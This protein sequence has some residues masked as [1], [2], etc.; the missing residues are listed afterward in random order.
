[1]QL[2]FIPAQE[3]FKVCVTVRKRL[4]VKFYWLVVQVNSNEICNAKGYCFFFSCENFFT[5]SVFCVFCDATFTFLL[6]NNEC[7]FF[8]LFYKPVLLGV[9]ASYEEPFL[10]ENLRTVTVCNNE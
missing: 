10:D 7:L 4:K 1:M 8:M 6:H 3:S 5:L 2:L 9:N